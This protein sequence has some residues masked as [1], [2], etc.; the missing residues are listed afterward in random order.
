M[1]DGSDNT[2]E[3]ENQ[4]EST[5]L[6]LEQLQMIDKYIRCRSS[7]DAHFDVELCETVNTTRAALLRYKALVSQKV[8]HDEALSR[9][10]GYQVTK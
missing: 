1:N 8:S 6:A 3:F 9:P 2:T 4:L 10:D 5:K 7:G